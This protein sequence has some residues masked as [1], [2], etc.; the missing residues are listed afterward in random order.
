MWYPLFKSI[1]PILVLSHLVLPTFASICQ[2]INYPPY[3]STIT[4]DW[5]KLCEVLRKD[6]KK[7]DFQKSFFTI[8]L[9]F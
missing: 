1:D 3:Y 2:K 7:S 8:F 6:L 9:P 5:L 4:R